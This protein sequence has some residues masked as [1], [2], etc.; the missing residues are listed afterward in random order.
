[1]CRVTIR[2][3]PNTTSSQQISIFGRARKFRDQEVI[4][5][6]LVLL[7]DN[8][9]QIPGG[10]QISRDE[11]GYILACNERDAPSTEK[12]GI[13]RGKPK[14]GSRGELDG[15]RHFEYAHQT[16]VRHKVSST[17][18]HRTTRMH[19]VDGDFRII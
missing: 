7:G 9:V 13:A 1:M 5:Y 2:V 11:V 18:C 6:D 17:R 8:L 16:G 19:G 3:P 10:L 15:I 4:A 14:E 12:F